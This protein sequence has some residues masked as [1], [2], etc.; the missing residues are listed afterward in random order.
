[1]RSLLGLLLAALVVAADGPWWLRGLVL[2]PALILG[3]GLPW[4]AW[5]DRHNRAPSSLQRGLDG[6]WIGLGLTWF[7][8]ALCREAG[9]SDP[10]WLIGLAALWT[11]L[12]AVMARG[13]VGGK[14]DR[15]E[16]YGLAAVAL[17]L[18]GLILLRPA[19]LA[20][21][22]DGYWWLQG[23]ADEGHPPMPIAAG[24]G[25][26]DASLLGWPE[27]GGMRLVPEPGQTSPTLRATAPVDGRVVLAMRGPI[28]AWLEVDPPGPPPPVRATVTR[29]PLEEGEA[30]PVRRYLDR[31]TAA[32]AIDLL[33]A[34]GQELPLRLG[35]PRADGD[36]VYLMPGTD[37]VWSL[38]AVGELRYTHYWQ[39]LNQVE[40]L[41]WALNV[42]R[43]LRFTLN[44]PPGWSP[45]LAVALALIRP[46]LP[47]AN[48]L[49]LWVC[50]FI[51]ATGVRM[52]ARV[53]PGLPPIALVVPAMLAAAIGLLMIEPA[54]ADFPDTLYA[55]AL[56]SV[57][58]ALVS[59]RAG[60]F[61]ALG[62]AAGL[63]RWPGVIAASLLALAWWSQVGDRPLVWRGLRRLWLLTAG[64]GALALL[65]ALTGELPDLAFVLWF[66]TFPEHWHG[67]SEPGALLSRVP[68][69]YAL[70]LAYTGGGLAV[71]ALSCALSAATPTRKARALLLGALAY[72]ALLATIDHHPSHYFLPLVALTGPAVV[73]GLAG[74]PRTFIRL[75]GGLLVVVGLWIFLATGRVW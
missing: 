55:A 20:R 53:A 54:S 50:A 27:A 26:Q 8:V 30:G 10:T 19:D 34:T 3:P 44:Q 22:L 35:G 24:D 70:W 75:G 72:S 61:A 15:S 32:V 74:A 13:L 59:G 64:G 42:R 5:L 16:A 68:G 43:D 23:A 41:D 4:A 49:F 58:G 47:G 28:G 62:I 71:A 1:L 57:A 18:G 9:W 17:A 31:G 36:A 12:G 29:S 56:L 73:G 66:E 6:V 52:G 37:A 67:E 65:G 60:W 48:A 69:F 25:W 7:D 2:P 14:L 51:G 46:D 40:N 33:L 63:L 39:I 38:H 11:V 45:I 21:P